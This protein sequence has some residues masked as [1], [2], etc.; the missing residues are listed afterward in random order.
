M[1]TY[2]DGIEFTDS[3][4]SYAPGDRLNDRFTLLGLSA[5]GNVVVREYGRGVDAIAQD[6]AFE[7]WGV[8]VVSH[9]YSLCDECGVITNLPGSEQFHN[10]GCS[11]YLSLQE[12]VAQRNQK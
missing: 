2:T 3:E 9:H 5:R 6:W 4:R 11:H 10:L 7:R 8:R 1:R 12:R